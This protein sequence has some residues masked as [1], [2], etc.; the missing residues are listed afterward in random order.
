MYIKTITRTSLNL[1][2]SHFI[3]IFN[4]NKLEE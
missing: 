3:L 4:I 1:L 2:I